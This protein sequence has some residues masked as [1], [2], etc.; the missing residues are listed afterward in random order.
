MS[1]LSLRVVLGICGAAVLGAAVFGFFAATSSAGSQ[2]A[3]IKVFVAP[4][5]I[6]N[7]ERGLVT[8]KFDNP[9]PGTINQVAIKITFDKP[10]ADLTPLG[11]DPGCTA[12]GDA[13]TTVVT[14][15]VGQVAAGTRVL[16]YVTFTA[17]S[18]LT[19]IVVK[20]DATFDE[21]GAGGG[22]KAVKSAVTAV[23]D[24]VSVGAATPD[25]KTGCIGRARTL[26]TS[27]ASSTNVNT[28]VTLQS[29]PTGPCA[30]VVIEE[31]TLAQEATCGGN[32]C[33]TAGSFVT[34]PGLAT[35]EITFYFPPP[36]TMPATLSIYQFAETTSTTS[37]LVPSCVTAGPT[38]V[39]SITRYPS[40]R[41][42]RAVLNVTGA[43]EDPGFAG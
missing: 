21:S 18:A 39:V 34:F 38:C 7:G 32:A 30:P 12:S 17:G 16:R 5:T 2:N 25:K 43:A 41:Q 33:T 4:A 8:A 42:I 31:T 19:T 28:N 20:A 3:S 23:S 37:V 1:G 22:K 29:T 36:G 24:P 13:E 11:L 35:V 9:M 15:G 27:G 14:C 6:T 26:G 10:S 40:L